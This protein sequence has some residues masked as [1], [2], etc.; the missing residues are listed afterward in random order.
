MIK[1]QSSFVHTSPRKLRLVAAKLSGMPA[2]KAIDVLKA[3]PHQGAKYLLKVVQQGVGNAKNNFKMSPEK[4]TIATVEI[5][6]GPRFKRRDKSHGA[7]FDSGM[8]M[9]KM[10]H[11]TVRMKEEK[12]GS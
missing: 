1:A 9:R 3:L 11:I 12:H 7:R 5:G 4:L 8:K 6:E 2:Q 10:A